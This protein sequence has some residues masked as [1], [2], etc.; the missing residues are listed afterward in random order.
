MFF[1]ILTIVVAS[2]FNVATSLYVHIVPRYPE[3]AV[4]KSIGISPRKM[5]VL[6]SMQGLILGAAGCVGGI[7][8]GIV[9]GYIFEWAQVHLGIVPQEIYRIGHINLS[10][11]FLDLIMVSVTTLFICLVATLAPA[12]KGARQSPVEGLR[13]E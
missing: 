7:L 3:I 4:L 8:T 13:Y 10:F 2:S 11:R 6:L 1:V 5:L 9:L 12:L